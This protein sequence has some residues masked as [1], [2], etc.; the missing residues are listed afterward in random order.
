M[1]THQYTRESSGSTVGA[2][3]NHTYTTSVFTVPAGER[4]VRMKVY[5]GPSGAQGFLMRGDAQT[6]FGGGGMWDTWKSSVTG[7]WSNGTGA[8]VAVHNG[9]EVSRSKRLYAVFETEDLPTYTITCKASGNGTLTANK[10][11]AYQGQTVTL[12]P[13]PATGYKLSKYTSSPN[14]TI[15]SN[16]FSMPAS[17][18]T[19][20]ATFT[21]QSYAL[22]VAT[23]D[24]DKGTV[25]GGGTYAYGS[26][27]TITANPKPGYKFVNWTK[28]AGTIANDN[29]ATT[30]FT[31]PASAATVT[32]HFERSQSVIGYYN[33]EEF[34]DCTVAVYDGEAFVDCDVL[35]YE[36]SEWKQCSKA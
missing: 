8:K 32:A 27:V 23:E 17:N 21:N 16:K 25:S 28:T 4:F 2:G 9:G 3:S 26:S 22:T 19:I 10:A 30:T 36:G 5:L 12:T 14:V 18:V 24:S 20:T 1:A 11:T 35:V 31:I 15:S 29:A 7:V 6:V 13:K 34:E 33:G